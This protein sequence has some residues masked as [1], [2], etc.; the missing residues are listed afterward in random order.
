MDNRLISIKESSGKDTRYTYAVGRIRVLETRLLKRSVLERM[1]EQPSYEDSLRVLSESSHYRQFIDSLKDKTDFESI[2]V[3]EL[4]QLYSLASELSLH[5]EITGIFL[6][7]YDLDNLRALIQAKLTGYG[8]KAE[9]IELGIFKID[10]LRE[11]LNKNDFRVLGE[12]VENFVLSMLESKPPVRDLEVAFSKFYITLLKD[13]L[14][15]TKS[16]FLL[17]ISR[18]MTDLLNIKILIRANRFLLKENLEIDFLGSGY[19]GEDFLREML[20]KEAPVLTNEFS[21]TSYNELVKKLLEQK[22]TVPETMDILIDN[23]LMNIIKEAK[24][25]NFGIEPLIGYIFAKEYE[26][27]HLRKIL[28]GKIYSVENEFIKNSLEEVYV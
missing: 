19:L 12:R 10:I 4:K 8:E 7:K 14:L 9:F 17:H 23:Y 13:A 5:K 22:E 11:C 15:K 6:L 21:R 26:V 3:Q 24:F 27:R 2:F 25:F 16:P 1:S 28:V 20:S 18:V